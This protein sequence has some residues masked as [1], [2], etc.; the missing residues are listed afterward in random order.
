[1]NALYYPFHLCH[2]TTLH[3]LLTDYECI[4]FRDYMALQLTPLVGTIAFPDRMGD[5]YP[6]FL[7]TGRIIQGHNV[8][9][10]MSSEVIVSANRDLVDPEWRSSFHKALTGDYRFQRGLFDISQLQQGE[11]SEFRDSSVWMELTKLDWMDVPYQVELIQALSR[12]RLSG[13]AAFRF[14]YGFALL[15][16]AAALVYTIR[17]CQQLNLIAVTDSVSH[18]GLL[19]RTC[20]RDG[21]DL[22]NSCVRR[23]E[24]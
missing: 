13:D 10:S 15:K 12:T 16:T 2:E 9:G 18:H 14:E 19:A 5:Y 8:S 17:L 4:H 3:R 24:Y 21:I 23:E 20:E 22:A 1:M 6:E 7:A 11:N